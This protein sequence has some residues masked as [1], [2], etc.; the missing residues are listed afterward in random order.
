MD[1]A[2]PQSEV[3]GPTVPNSASGS[4]GIKMAIREPPPQALPPMHLNDSGLPYD[5]YAETVAEQIRTQLNTRANGWVLLSLFA[6][7]GVDEVSTVRPPW[8]HGHKGRSHY[9][10][11]VKDWLGK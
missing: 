8:T 3:R 5:P 2:V 4:G 11:R 1:T 10:G 9:R 6:A 7:G